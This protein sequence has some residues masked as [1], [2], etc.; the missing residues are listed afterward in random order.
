[1]A[2]IFLSPGSASLKFLAWT[3]LTSTLYSWKFTGQGLQRYKKKTQLIYAC[4]SWE[5]I[6][7]ASRLSIWILKWDRIGRN[8]PT[9]SSLSFTGAGSI[10]TCIKSI[11][12]SFPTPRSH[13]FGCYGVL[14]AGCVCASTHGYQPIWLPA[15]KVYW[16]EM[17]RASHAASPD[18][19]V[20]RT[21]S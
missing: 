18:F 10:S 2:L 7:E 13:V 16:F 12:Y 19:K 20:H 8:C 4:R 5:V 14:R 11:Q 6:Y 21:C 15:S 1:M 9:K 3:I 17:R